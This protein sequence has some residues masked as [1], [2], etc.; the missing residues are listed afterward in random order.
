M[1][2]SP[3][4]FLPSGATLI[5]PSIL[6]TKGFGESDWSAAEGAKDQTLLNIFFSFFLTLNFPLN[7]NP[8]PYLPQNPKMNLPLK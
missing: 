1:S 8:F 3:E 7:C 2:E 5:L 6:S 4:G